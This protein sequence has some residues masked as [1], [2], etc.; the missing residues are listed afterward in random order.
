MLGLDSALKVDADGFARYYRLREQ[1]LSALRDGWIEIDLR[2]EPEDHGGCLRIGVRDS[3]AGF[4]IARALAEQP[5]TGKLSGRGLALVRE[6][7]DGCAADA[8][9]RGVSVEFRWRREA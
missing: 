7:S 2:V 4:D 1:R 3:G 5:A 9:G 8:D 6:L